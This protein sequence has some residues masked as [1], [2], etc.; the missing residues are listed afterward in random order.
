MRSILYGLVQ[1]TGVTLNSGCFPELPGA[2]TCP[3]YRFRC[4]KSPS[5]L[6][7]MNMGSILCG[8]MQ[9][10]GVTLN[11]GCYPELPGARTCPVYR[12][13]CHKSPSALW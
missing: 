4:H 11:S 13:R 12:F 2:R 10:T 8:L 6:W 5:L 3:V 1:S 7:Y 9:S